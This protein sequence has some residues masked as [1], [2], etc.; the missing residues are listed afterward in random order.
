[1]STT[2]LKAPPAGTGNTRSVTGSVNSFLNNI[3]GI[4]G[5]LADTWGKLQIYKAEAKAYTSESKPVA[6]GAE[7]KKYVSGNGASP[8]TG[9]Q[10]LLVGGGVL[11]GGLLLYVLLKKK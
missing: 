5:S 6:D 3:V 8:V 4:G 10:L 1:M 11:A 2:T 7:D 9:N